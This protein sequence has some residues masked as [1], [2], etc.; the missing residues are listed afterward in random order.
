MEQ[1]VNC[2]LILD[3][4]LIENISG[5]NQKFDI[6]FISKNSKRYKLSFTK[7]WDMRYSIENGYIERFCR[8]R[9]NLPD[10]IIDNGIYIVEDSDYTKYFE[11][12]VLGSR[13][14]K[15]IV[16]YLLYDEIDTTIEILTLD[17]PKISEI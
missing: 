4:A 13:P 17:S 7:V 16:D 3:I 14:T 11:K 2:E 6:F 8:F 15:D 9:E 12:Q 5:G 10:G 1:L